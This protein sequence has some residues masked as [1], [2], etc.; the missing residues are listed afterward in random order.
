[1]GITRRRALA[2]HDARTPV[3]FD[4]DAP[5]TREGYYRFRAGMPAATKRALAFAPH[6]DL[7]WVE[8]GDPSLEVATRLGRA[9]RDAHPAKGLV[10][11]L[12]PSFNW[13]AHGFTPDTLRSFVWDLAREGFVLQLVSLAGLHSTAA[14]SHELARAFR[15]DGM[16]AYVDLVQRRERDAGCDVLTHQKWSGAAYI[17][18]ILGAIQSGSSGSKSMGQGG[19]E[20]QFD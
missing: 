8:T 13:M 17:D 9:V 18:G 1:M 5:R 6:A 2:A 12:S 19:T 20:S 14:A 10:Y 4:W 11:N 16:K 3:R 15:A 7:L